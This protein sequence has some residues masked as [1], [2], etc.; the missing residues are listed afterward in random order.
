MGVVQRKG[1]SSPR[2]HTQQPCGTLL[3]PVALFCLPLSSG[4]LPMGSLGR[5]GLCLG[6]ELARSWGSASVQIG[7]SYGASLKPKGEFMAS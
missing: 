1:S 4:A 6:E 2:F 7:T 3:C 5:Q